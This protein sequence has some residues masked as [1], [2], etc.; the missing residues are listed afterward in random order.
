[1][2]RSRP[3]AAVL[4]LLAG[5]LLL[6]AGCSPKSK[7]GGPGDVLLSTGQNGDLVQ[8]QV[9]NGAQ[10][11][12]VHFNDASV[13][14]PSVSADGSR[15]AFVR[16][17]DFTVGQTDFGTDIYI[18]ARNGSDPSPLVKHAAPSEL[19]RWPVWLPDGRT[20]IFQ[21][22]G[23]S[24]AGLPTSRLDKIDIASGVRSRYI[25]NALTPA[26]SRDARTLTY[27]T[28]DLTTGLQQ[29][30]I[31]DAADTAPQ[32]VVKSSGT[33]GA[34]GYV[35]PSP[36]GSRIAFGAASLG[37]SRPAQREAL[38]SRPINQTPFD[39]TRIMTDGLPEDIWVVGRDGGGLKRLSAL[40]EDQP[41][42]AWSADG[43]LLYSMGGTGL[44]RIDTISGDKR[45]VVPGVVHGEIVLAPPSGS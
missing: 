6:A 9:A 32:P 1:V 36:D 16:S 14:D 37:A 25:D 4:L 40:A 43:R 42:L 38:I 19:L 31:T 11:A 45:R 13:L 24:V 5:S 20:L 26:I 39:P 10:A 18:A 23:A 41:S 30:W 2:I 7:G 33:L 17:P 8:I 12:V 3:T 35:A 22:Q 15:I 34:F 21:V 29:I 28:T 27:V 44:W